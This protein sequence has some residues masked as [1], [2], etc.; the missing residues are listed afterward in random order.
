MIKG[1]LLFIIV[2]CYFSV[3]VA[4]TA[5]V[6]VVVVVAFVEVGYT[7]VTVDAIVIVFELYFVVAVVAAFDTVMHVFVVVATFVVVV[8]PIAA[9]ADAIEDAFDTIIIVVFI[10]MK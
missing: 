7:A 3:A 8:L 5:Y 1:N 2:N 10:I 6:A 4:E 9:S